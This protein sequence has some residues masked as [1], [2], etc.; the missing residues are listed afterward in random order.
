MSYNFSERIY[1]T[2]LYLANWGK[3]KVECSIC[4]TRFYSYMSEEER[5]KSEAEGNKGYYCSEGC[6]ATL[7]A[8]SVRED[9]PLEDREELELVSCGI[10]NEKI[11]LSLSPK[12]KR[13]GKAYFCLKCDPTNK[14]AD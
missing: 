7:L 4:G 10:C 11:L 14:N 5:L 1:N 13:K 8:R 6:M 3:T 12:E 2:Y 9:L